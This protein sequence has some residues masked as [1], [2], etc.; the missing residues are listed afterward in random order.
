MIDDKDVSDRAKSYLETW[1]NEQLVESVMWHAEPTWIHTFAELWDGMVKGEILPQGNPSPQWR[2]R[3]TGPGT[4][5]FIGTG[6]L[7]GHDSVVKLTQTDI[8]DGAP[9]HVEVVYGP[10][11][12][13]PSGKVDES[14]GRK[15]EPRRDGDG[16]VIYDV[17][18]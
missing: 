2:P 14:L 6:K 10:I 8:D 18:D 4:W 7:N 1:N 16:Q 12:D 13:L 17:C 5:V 3:P 9:F 11:P 15:V